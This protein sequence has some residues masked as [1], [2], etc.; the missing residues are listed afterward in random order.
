MFSNE[1]ACESLS[2]FVH[3]AVKIKQIRP[4]QQHHLFHVCSGSIAQQ[5]WQHCQHIP[6]ITRTSILKHTGCLEKKW[7]G[8][9]SLAQSNLTVCAGPFATYNH[10]RAWSTWLTCALTTN[11]APALLHRKIEDNVLTLIL[12]SNYSKW[13]TPGNWKSIMTGFVIMGYWSSSI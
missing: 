4:A 1:L 12:L 3:L 7:R 5:H 6:I 11:I 9:C 2:V 13:I 10:P 8:L